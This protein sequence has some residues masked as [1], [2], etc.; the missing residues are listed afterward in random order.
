MRAAR[1]MVVR[2]EMLVVMTAVIVIVAVVR[3][4][5]KTVV[6]V[7]AVAVK[8]MRV[9]RVMEVVNRK[10]KTLMTVSSDVRY[11]RIHSSNFIS[12]YTAS[13]LLSSLLLKSPLLPS[14]PFS[15]RIDSCFFS[16]AALLFCTSIIPE[17]CLRPPL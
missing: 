3:V 17:L 10:I 15:L 9:V 6:V 2:A 5:V 14:P 7:R 12:T 16:F 11:Q 8:M 13:V 1:V 4:M